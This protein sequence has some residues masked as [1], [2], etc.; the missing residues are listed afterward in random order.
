MADLEPGTFLLAFALDSRLSA[1]LTDAF[2]DAP[3]T[4]GDFGVTSALRLTEPTRPG[5]LAHLLGMRPTTMSNYLRRLADRGLIVREPDPHDGR[6]AR[7]RL[8]PAGVASTEACFPGFQRAAA[9]YTLALGEVGLT[10]DEAGRQLGTLV[11]A[12]RLALEIL[13]DGTLTTADAPS[14]V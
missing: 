3:L 10:W 12:M 13:A 6:A 2:A 8:T 5:D 7:V 9:A 4:P 11:N 14:A 1:L